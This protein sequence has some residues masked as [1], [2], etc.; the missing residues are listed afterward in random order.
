MTFS[1]CLCI[2]RGTTIYSANYRVTHC[3]IGLVRVHSVRYALTP[4]KQ[5][6]IS[7][8]ARIGKVIT[9][10]TINVNW[11]KLHEQGL[12]P[13][14]LVRHQQAWERAGYKVYFQVQDQKDLTILQK[15]TAPEQPKPQAAY[16]LACFFLL[17]VLASL[18]TIFVGWVALVR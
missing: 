12:D 5:A 17:G 18:T 11:S 1:W 13:E 14:A 8:L 2:H 16:Q 4:G 9:M 3:F 6:I 10:A 15:M 7:S